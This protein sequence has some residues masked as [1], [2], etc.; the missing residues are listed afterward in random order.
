[1]Y[2]DDGNYVGEGGPTSTGLEALP[3]VDHAAMKYPPFRRAFY[4][5]HSDVRAQSDA[6]VA[7][8]RTELGIVAS[9]HDVVRPIK[10]FMQAGAW[11][12]SCHYT[13]GIP[14]FWAYG[15][16]FSACAQGLACRARRAKAT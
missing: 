14:K 15:S 11:N 5:E 1:M 10:S 7:K 3:S 13:G 8:F 16:V 12:A 6:D 2:D 9:G 4:S